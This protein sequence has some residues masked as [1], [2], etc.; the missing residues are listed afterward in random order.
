MMQM[1]KKA[2]NVT[3]SA[4]MPLLKHSPLGLHESWLAIR[5]NVLLQL[6]IKQKI[7]FRNDYY[8]PNEMISGNKRNAG[9]GRL[10]KWLVLAGFGRWKL[11]SRGKLQTDP[12]CCS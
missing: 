8:L 1:K 9:K 4:K 7:T 2:M 12:G 6:Y 3:A 11:V 10:K 5:S